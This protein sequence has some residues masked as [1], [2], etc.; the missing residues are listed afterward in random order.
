MGAQNT[1]QGQRN[2]RGQFVTDLTQRE[3]EILALIMQGE[4]PRMI[5]EQLF[6]SI[7]TVRTHL[8]HIYRKAGVKRCTQLLREVIQN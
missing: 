5:A 2:E 6:I 1:G 7:Y 3:R 8:T 4:T